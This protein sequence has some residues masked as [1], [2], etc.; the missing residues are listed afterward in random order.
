MS[1]LTADLGKLSCQGRGKITLYHFS[2]HP[3][4]STLPM[5]S[6]APLESKLRLQN[7]RAQFVD[8]PMV[9]F[10]ELELQ[11][12]QQCWVAVFSIG[13]IVRFSNAP[14]RGGSE[15]EG[16]RGGRGVRG[17]RGGT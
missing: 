3:L 9:E 10:F 6:H 16:G 14:E 12:C 11:S 8:H 17:V 4:T 7:K 13:E 15:S 2:N 5:S 1:E